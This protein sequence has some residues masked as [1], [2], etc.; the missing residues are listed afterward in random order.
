MSQTVQ[1]PTQTIARNRNGGRFGQLQYPADGGTHG[2]YIMFKEY[3]YRQGSIS[4]VNETGSIALP[5][6]E[7]IVDSL[8]INS[9]AGELG[10]IGGAVADIISGGGNQMI[11]GLLQG[12]LS[13][14]E[15]VV[16][17]TKD[18]LGGDT[19]GV[20]GSI[21]TSA[22]YANYMARAGLTS[23]SPEVG[24]AI[25]AAT[26][27]AVNP[28]AT[29]T[30]EGVA[31]KNFDLRWQ[32]APKNR[33]EANEIANI[34]RTIKNKILPRYQPIAGGG[35][36]VSRGLLKY[37]HFADIYFVGID[38]RKIFRFKRSM[39]NTFTVDYSPQGNV[40]IKGGA[41]SVPAFV[42]I[43]MGFVEA[44]IWTAEDFEGGQDFGGE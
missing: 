40:F 34:I 10:V 3:S 14:G 5:L 43:S 2:V 37:P 33:D 4:G 15:G 26:G 7:N 17:I 25:S 44:E 23:L 8:S 31:L 13:A 12:A 19:S 38:P 1:I 27:T 18:L 9:R 29:V 30:F 6:P 39:V 21:S 32:L 24:S 42:N 22:S 36:S 35:G 20:T 11:Q 16:D 28:H 41:G